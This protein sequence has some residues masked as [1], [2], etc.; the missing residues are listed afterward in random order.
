V[1][2]IDSQLSERKR[3][4]MELAL[5][6][7][8]EG[9]VDAGW[10]DVVLLHNCLPEV[11]FDDI[12]MSARF[13]GHALQVPIWITGM[14]GGH[15]GA[16]AI[17]RRLA[18]AAERYGMAMGL[19]SQRAALA[20]ESLLRTYTS[21]RKAAPSAV[22]V[23]NIGAP[24]L[25]R[26]NRHDG[27]TVQQIEGLVRSLAAQGLAVHLNWAQELM[28]PEGDR[29]AVGC[30][31]AIAHVVQEISV[32]VLVKETGAGVSRQ[33]ADLLASI[34]VAALD[35]GGAGG[36]SMIRIEQKRS[37]KH[38]PQ[39]D[40]IARTFDEWGIPT[41]ASVLETRRA[42]LPIVATGGVRT[43][44][45]AARALALGADLVGVGGPFLKAA[46]I[47]EDALSA[48]V[49]KFIAELRTAMFLSGSNSVM[50]LAR[51][52]YVL[53]GKTL[54]WRQQREV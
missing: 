16:E 17:N 27:L 53:H 24:Q 35:V 11:N 32:P 36:T 10:S 50:S 42:G 21:A 2:E 44:L 12:D 38:N 26:Q 15:D 54:A 48:A 31:D 6:P 14:T 13:L 4:H 7:E 1:P 33:Q 19:G 25:V 39:F 5:R 43:G 51:A 29:N 41:A 30:L 49:E 47:G 52:D 34:G 9:A 28:Q 40:E 3:E 37:E 22:L 20:D 45:D 18:R 8:S 46:V 23:A